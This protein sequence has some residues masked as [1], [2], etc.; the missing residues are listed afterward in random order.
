MG[1][2]NGGSVFVLLLLI[3]IRHVLSCDRKASRARAS[4][5]KRL[6]DAQLCH[7]HH[8]FELTK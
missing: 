5:R 2:K 1:N 4:L 3:E 8:D 6:V 7:R